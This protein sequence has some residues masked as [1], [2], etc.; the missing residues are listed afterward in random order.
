MIGRGAIRNPWLFAQIR[1]HL[2]G[3][4]V[5]VPIG[6]DVLAYVDAL[7][8]AVCTPGVREASQV[9]K[10]KKYMNHLGAGV[11]PSGAFLHQIRRTETRSEFFRVCYE[12]LDHDR[13]LDLEAFHATATPPAA[14][15]AAC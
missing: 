11:E 10:M 4:S 12:F 8:E 7:Y 9:Q 3:A 15:I 1:A 13:P 14:A 2:A 6:R 5:P